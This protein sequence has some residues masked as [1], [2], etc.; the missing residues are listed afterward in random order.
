MC[1]YYKRL[2]NTALD[3]MEHTWMRK[4]RSWKRRKAFVFKFWCSEPWHRGVWCEVTNVYGETA[5]GFSSTTMNK[6]GSLKYAESRKGFP[7]GTQNGWVL[8]LYGFSV[9]GACTIAPT[10]HTKCLRAWKQHQACRA[11]G[12]PRCHPKLSLD[13]CQNRTLLRSAL[14]CEC[15]QWR[16][17]LSTFRRN[18]S[19]PY[20]SVKQCS[21]ARL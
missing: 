18:L 16:K 3:W 6:C 15:T 8:V 14:F 19:V 2:A 9:G 1:H 4:M 17:V 10:R 13:S 5:D 21:P 7:P 20:P 11:W 12:T